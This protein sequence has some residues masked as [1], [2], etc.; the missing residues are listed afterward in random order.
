MS[1]TQPTDEELHEANRIFAV[2]T[3]CPMFEGQ[4]RIACVC[5]NGRVAISPEGTGA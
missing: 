5:F 3:E 2:T 4:C 1:V